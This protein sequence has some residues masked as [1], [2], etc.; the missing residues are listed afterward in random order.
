MGSMMSPLV[1]LDDEH[2]LMAVAGA[3]GG[4]RIRPALLQV[5]IRMLRG[6]APQDAIDAPRLN[7]L[8]GLVRVE[9]GFSPE[10]LDALAAR[11]AV[12]AADRRDPYFGGVSA[13]SPLGGG[14]DPRRSGSV[15]LL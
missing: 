8:P 4:S 14:A 13:L 15:V 1:A 2:R 10:V 7:P 9:P 11:S 5:L 12:A 3:A 6:A